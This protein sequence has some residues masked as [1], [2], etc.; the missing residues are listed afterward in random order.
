MRSISPFTTFC[1]VSSIGAYCA[2][3]KEGGS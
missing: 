1:G 2:V 3:S